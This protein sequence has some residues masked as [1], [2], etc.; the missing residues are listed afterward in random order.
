MR[1]QGRLQDWNDQKGY[2]FVAPNGGGERA[3]V[4]IKAF[5]RRPQRPADGMLISYELQRDARGR[6]NAVAVRQQA[7][8]GRTPAP[9]RRARQRSNTRLPRAWMGLAALLVIAAAWWLKWLPGWTALTVAGMSVVTLLAYLHDKAAAQADRRRTPEK[10]LHL[11][12]LCGGW[13][14]ALIAQQVFQH[15]RSKPS[16]LLLFWVTVALNIIALAAIARGLL[17]LP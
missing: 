1:Y 14:G 6:S 7:A 3:F 16:F 5:E 4:H 8:D 11:L 17:P 10:T 12:A 2:G 9:A 13:P 15:K